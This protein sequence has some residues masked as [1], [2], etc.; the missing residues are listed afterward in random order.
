MTLMHPSRICAYAT[1][2]AALFAA[3]LAMAEDPLTTQAT[4]LDRIQIE[5]IVTKYY[6]DITS[7]G[8]K[9]ISLHYA[10]DA[11]FD[12]NGVVFK[13]HDEIQLMYGTDDN[14]GAPPGGHFNMLMNNPLIRVNGN[15]A[16]ADAIF[17]GIISDSVTATPRLYEQGLDHMEFAKREGRWLITRRVI[18]SHGGMP[19][20]ITER[21]Q[22]L[23]KQKQKRAQ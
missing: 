13:G 5:D 23:L 10:K 17:T 16:T 6:W 3:S 18:T 19:M 11:T 7:G 22:K 1:M 14:M 9:D 2:V 21:L 4:L 15:T 12:V 8:R 20:D